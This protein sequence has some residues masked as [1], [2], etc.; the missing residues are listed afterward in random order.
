MS[1]VCQ[2]RGNTQIRVARGRKRVETGPSPIGRRGLAIDR[3]SSRIWRAGES[4]HSFE[5]IT[6]PSVAIKTHFSPSLCCCSPRFSRLVRA[7]CVQ[8]SLAHG[9]RSSRKAGAIRFALCSRIIYIQTGIP[10]VGKYSSIRFL[11]VRMK[12]V[13]FFSHA[14]LAAR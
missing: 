2:Q 7:T 14:A 4:A 6:Y 12:L 1:H 11:A 13:A 10:P 8:M 3:F 9:H 5:S